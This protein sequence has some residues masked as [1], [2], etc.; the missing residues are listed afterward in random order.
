MKKRYIPTQI[1][2]KAWVRCFLRFHN[3]L[4]KNGDIVAYNDAGSLTLCPQ[5]SNEDVN[6][7]TITTC[8]YLVIFD[9]TFS[10][11]DSWTNREPYTNY[12]IWI[13]FVGFVKIEY[14]DFANKRLLIYYSMDMRTGSATAY[15]FDTV[16]D[17]VIWSGGCQ[18]GIKLDITSTNLLENERAKQSGDLNMIMGLLSSAVSI[19][20]GVATEN[21]VAIV[22]G[23]L[24]AGKSVASNVNTHMNV[25]NR[26]S[27]MFGSNDG[28]IYEN[29]TVKL[30]ASTHN[31]V[32]AINDTYKKLNGLPYR[33]YGSLSTLTGYTEIGD[34]QFNASNNDIYNVEIDEIVALLKN[35]V[36]L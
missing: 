25:F 35:G 14:K 7:K 22:G 16:N 10:I 5:G 1:R 19:G 3:Q 26:A 9:G 32:S 20:V 13:P 15:I 12:E 29:L 36:I 6:Y 28:S 21:P 18:L 4:R 27:T 8:P 24:S 33:E 23:V 11:T 31:S 2:Q 17:N 34:I 30:R